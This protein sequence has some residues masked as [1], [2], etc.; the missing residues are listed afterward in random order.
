[1]CQCTVRSQLTCPHTSPASPSTAQHSATSTCR[2]VEVSCTHVSRVQT[3]FGPEW[4][5][6]H[7][8]RSSTQW[9]EC[10]AVHGHR[11]ENRTGY[12]T[13]PFHHCS[14]E[15]NKTFG[16]APLTRVFN[17]HGQRSF[18]TEHR[19]HETTSDQRTLF[20]KP[21]IRKLRRKRAAAGREVRNKMVH[22][23]EKSIRNLRLE[24]PETEQNIRFGSGWPVR[25]CPCGHVLWQFRIAG[26]RIN[27]C[28]FCLFFSC[29]H[30]RD[31]RALQCRFRLLQFVLQL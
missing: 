29:R 18:F 31:R 1:M 16:R 7:K 5:D 26:R 4:P 10:V 17:H 25:V 11:V 8:L 24:G 6:S 28:S 20:C 2:R 9:R 22:F 19:I 23:R 27:F 13:E 3:N 15:S 14:A 21:E 30:F 12:I